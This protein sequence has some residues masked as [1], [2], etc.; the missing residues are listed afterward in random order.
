M[1]GQRGRM[2][3]VLSRDVAW[4]RLVDADCG[5]RYSGAGGVRRRTSFLETWAAA[6]VA[7]AL[8][9]TPGVFDLLPVRLHAACSVAGGMVR[10][11]RRP[12][13]RYSGLAGAG[14]TAVDGRRTW[15]AVVTST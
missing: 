5:L 12:P 3:G 2:T 14:L 7:Q 8:E 11:P 1:T 4:A 10:E 6:A 15:T 13:V 9:R